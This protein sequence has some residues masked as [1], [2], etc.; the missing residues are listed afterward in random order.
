MSDSPWIDH[1]ANAAKRGEIR[2]RVERPG[3]HVGEI[4]KMA[5]EVACE[6]LEE[7]LSNVHCPSERECE[8]IQE[9]LEQSLAHAQSTYPD[10]KTMLSRAYDFAS[11]RDP[12]VPH[13][14]TGPAGTGKTQLLA[15]IERA[16]VFAPSYIDCLGGH[17]FPFL[18]VR[19]VVVEAS[20]SIGQVFEKLMS[21]SVENLNGDENR[22]EA[23]EGH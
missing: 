12:Y 9:I 21:A 15:A 5:T 17:V 1:F 7:A 4:G 19:R 6:R 16:L 8:I 10:R 14:I 13:L 20:S 2:R 23:N 18:P 3:K 11:V 22:K